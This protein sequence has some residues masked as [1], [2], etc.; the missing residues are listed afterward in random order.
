MRVV[1]VPGQHKKAFER[2]ASLLRHITS[3]DDQ[4][5]RE[6]HSQFRFPVRPRSRLGYVVEQIYAAGQMSDRFSPGRAPHS[7]SPGSQKVIRCL[8]P[9]PGHCA[10]VGEH[11]GFRVLRFVA[12]FREKIYDAF[13]KLLAPALE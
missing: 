1:R 12:Y 9:E 11:F 6:S 10:V 4:G 8:L 7:V 13:V 3:R 5:A 2:L